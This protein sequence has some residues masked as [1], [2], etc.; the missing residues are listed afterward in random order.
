MPFKQ[1]ENKNLKANLIIKEKKQKIG[2]KTLVYPHALSEW[3][4][5]CRKAAHA[6]QADVLACFRE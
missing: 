4:E 5:L 2:A 1:P 3:Q 6:D